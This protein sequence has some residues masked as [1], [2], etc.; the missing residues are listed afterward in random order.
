MGVGAKCQG[1]AGECRGMPGECMGVCV[2][3][4]CNAGNARESQENM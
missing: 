4:Q 3:C 2:N 1:I